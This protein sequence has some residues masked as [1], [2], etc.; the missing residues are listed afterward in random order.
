VEDLPQV[1]LAGNRLGAL[2]RLAQSGEEDANEDRN[3]PDDDQEFDQRETRRGGRA[4]DGEM[5]VRS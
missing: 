4:C 3:D 1:R 5:I 2:A